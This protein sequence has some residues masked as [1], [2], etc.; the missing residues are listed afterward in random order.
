M[1]GGPSSFEEIMARLRDRT[2]EELVL[3]AAGTE[4]AVAQGEIEL[5]AVA[6]KIIRGEL[7]DDELAE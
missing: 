4:L 1:T 7:G 3:M 5:E 2:P 6:L